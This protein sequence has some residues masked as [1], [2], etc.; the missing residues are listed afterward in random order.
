M[1]Y[2]STLSL[3]L[4]TLGEC[5]AEPHLSWQRATRL[6]KGQLGTGHLAGPLNRSSPHILGSATNIHDLRTG[7]PVGLELTYREQ[8]IARFLYSTLIKSYR[9]KFASRIEA[10]EL[11]FSLSGMLELRPSD[12]TTFLQP[13]P[14][15]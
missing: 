13:A 1:L 8:H 2:I 11:E 10:A 5:S 9:P 6:N 14:R 4:S 7:R 3:V 15:P 12:H